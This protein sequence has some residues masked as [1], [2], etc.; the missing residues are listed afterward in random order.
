MERSLAGNQSDR[1][2]IAATGAPGFPPRLAGVVRMNS[3][4]MPLLRIVPD[5]SRFG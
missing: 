2:S 1:A 4:R 3:G 5:A